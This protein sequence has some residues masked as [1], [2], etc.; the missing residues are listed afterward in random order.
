MVLFLG[1]N[2]G[3]LS[4][5]VG[6]VL[7][8]IVGLIA[9]FSNMPKYFLIA[10][11]SIGG[12]VAVLGAVMLLLNKIQLDAFN[13]AAVSQTVTGSWFW[14]ILAVLL[15]GVGMVY[16]V[17]ANPEYTLEEWGTMTTPPKKVS[18]KVEDK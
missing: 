12:A 15:A 1:F 13:Y 5:I 17:K 2:K 8:A 18:S 11:S 16:Q 7:G 6:I 3:F 4:A 10:V 14:L 9:L